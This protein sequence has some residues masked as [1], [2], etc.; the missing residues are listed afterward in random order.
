MS[1]ADSPL[2]LA[3]RALQ[4]LDEVADLGLNRQHLIEAETILGAALGLDCTGEPG[5]W[6]GEGGVIGFDHN[7]DTCPVHEWL[8]E[9]D[10]VKLV[11]QEGR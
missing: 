4:R 7:G 1:V 3:L 2:G 6:N 10:Q 11:T 9:S 8:V 5:S